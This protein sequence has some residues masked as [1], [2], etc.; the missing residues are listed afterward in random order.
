M[1]LPAYMTRRIYTVADAHAFIRA[2]NDDDAFFHLEDD[3]ADVY[4][5]D[6]V[7]LFSLPEVDAMRERIAEI[8]TLTNDPCQLA[9]DA[10]GEG[11]SEDF[12]EDEDRQTLTKA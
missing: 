9:A 7:P 2:L 12:D 3:P 1:P 11:D 10:I 4:I 6:T 8:L 5:N